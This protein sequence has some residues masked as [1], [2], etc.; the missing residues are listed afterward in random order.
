[1]IEKIR[2]RHKN[3]KQKHIQRFWNRKR[4][5]AKFNFTL[6]MCNKKV[7][8]QNYKKITIPCC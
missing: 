6:Q 4:N 7:L 2:P 3:D 1:M 8:L 5:Y